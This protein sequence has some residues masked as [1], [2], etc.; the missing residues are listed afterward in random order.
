[1]EK[2]I[3]KAAQ[4]IKNCSFGVALTGAGMSTESGIPDF[5]SPGGLWTEFEPE[6]VG[7]RSGFESSPTEFFEMAR[8]I[9]PTLLAARPNAGHKTLAKLEKMGYLK[10]VITQNIDGLHQNAGSKQVAEVH[11]TIYEVRCPGCPE[12]HTLDELVQKGLVEGQNPPL[13]DKCGGILRPNIVLFE[14]TLPEQ[15]FLNAKEWVGSCDLLLVAGSSLEVTPVNVLPIIAKQ[16]EARIIMV[17]DE[18]TRQDNLADIILRGKTGV[19]LPK[20]L[21]AIQDPYEK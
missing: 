17:N 1:M 18:P 11:G 10:G 16:N 6:S 5:R 7:S 19:I 20:I 13:C 9:G 2:A 3:R 14:E 12:F 21:Q 15:P 4:W 8:K